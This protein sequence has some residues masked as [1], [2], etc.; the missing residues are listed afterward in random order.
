MLTK[1]PTFI[2]N[3]PIQQSISAQ[4]QLRATLIWLPN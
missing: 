4:D 3:C 2:S 1:R